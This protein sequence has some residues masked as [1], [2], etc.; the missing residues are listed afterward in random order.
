VARTRAFAP[1]KLDVF[2]RGVRCSFPRRSAKPNP[3]VLTLIPFHVFAVC[4]RPDAYLGHTIIYP[5]QPG[6]YAITHDDTPGP[7]LNSWDSGGQQSCHLGAL[8]Y[9]VAQIVSVGL[10]PVHRPLRRTSRRWRMRQLDFRSRSAATYKAGRAMQLRS[11]AL[12][13][14]CPSI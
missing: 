2:W 13:L 5:T 10:V 12:P 6:A 7:A 14:T 11:L 3:E 9:R 1:S 8:S 4:R